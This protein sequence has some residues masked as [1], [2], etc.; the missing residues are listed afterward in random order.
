MKKIFVLGIALLFVAASAFSAPFSPELLKISAPAQQQYAFDGSTLTIPV[1]VTGTPAQVTFLVF[2]QDQASSIK[3]VVNG[4]LGWHTV[5]NIDTCLYVSAPVEM[6]KGANQVTW[7]GMDENGNMVPAG[8]YTYYLWGFDNVNPKTKASDFIK[9]SQHSSYLRIIEFDG[10]GNALVNPIVTKGQRNGAGDDGAWATGD[11]TPAISQKWALGGDPEDAGL[12][13]TCS[14]SFPG[15]WSNAMTMAFDL[16]DMQYF[17]AEIGNADTKTVAATRLQWVPNGDAIVDAAW[18]EDG[19]STSM[20]TWNGGNAESGIA[21][22][23]TYLYASM[24]NH[25]ISEAEANLYVWDST[26]GT[27]VQKFDISPWWSDPA[28]LEAAAQMNGGP[29]TLS[30]R[31]GLVYL[32]CHCAC[33]AQAVN[34][35]AGLNDED[36]FNVWVNDNGDYTRD[37]NFEPESPRPWICNDYN[38]GPYTYTLQADANGFSISPSYDM[39]AVSFAL[40]APDGTG[41]SY[42]AFGG[43]TAAL[44]RGQYYVDNGSAFDGIYSDNTTGAS[45]DVGLWF[46][47]HDSVKGT[48]TDQ[49]GVADA[50]PAAFTVSQNVPNPFN[51]T[52]TISFN[53]AQAGKTTVE[54]YNVAGQKVDTLV[55]SSLKAGSHSVTWNAAKFSAGVYFYTV[56]SGSFSKTT[57]MTLLK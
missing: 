12:L 39:G 25:Y 41:M 5:N 44:K 26:D 10:S 6:V 33:L 32:N 18:G 1:T 57:K 11:E 16:N 14:V 21:T 7:D 29:N 52:T 9:T 19:I 42:R 34:P 15:G 50:A 49:V 24:G 36:D 8:S 55:N 3:N 48:I 30:Y 31:D 35:V 54:V 51:P 47:G 37:H 17:Y 46:T 22:D 27:F 23:G 40:L 38:V 13:E 28:A 2:T 43:E 56:K 4:Y 20:G 53:L 45:G